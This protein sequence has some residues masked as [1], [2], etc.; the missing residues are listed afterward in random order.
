MSSSMKRCLALAASALMLILLSAAAADEFHLSL[1]V[2]ESVG[3]DRQAEA[4][5]GGVPLPKGVFH[6]DQQLALFKEDGT[7][8][9]CQVSPLVVETD[10]TLRWVLLDFQDH[11]AAGKTNRYRL[12][13][14]KP[15]VRPKEVLQIDDGP[16]EVT[17]DTGKIR[18]SVSRTGPFS[19]FDSV[20]VDGKAVISGGEVS[21]VQLQGR[22]GWDDRAAWRPRKLVAGPPDMV[23]VRYAGPL[24]VTIEVA[25]HFADDPLGAGYKAW[26]TA[27]AGKSRVWLKYKL[28]NSN[29]DRYTAIPVARSTLQLRL[30]R[31]AEEVLLGANRPLAAGDQGWIHQGLLLHYTYQDI[32][33]AVK[34]GNGDNMLWTGNGPKD[35]PAG[36]IATSGAGAVFVCD[37]LFSTNPARRLGADRGN[38]V[39]EGIAERFQ[40][41]KDR[42]FNQDRRVGQPWQSEGFWLYDCSHHT[43][44]YLFDFAPPS[45]PAALDRLAQATRNRLWV[46]A[47]GEYYS[48]CEVLGTGRFGT[49]ADET[50][51]YREW[52]WSFQ[53]TQIPRRSD[54]LPGAF[55]AWEDNHYESEA[56]SVQGLLLMYLRT[57]QRGWFDLAE[58]WARYHMDLQAWRTDGWRWKDG[59]IWFPQGGPQGNRPQREK[60]NFLWGPDWGDRKGSPDCADLWRLAQGKSCYCHYYGSGLADY[61][62]LSGDRDALDAAIDNVEQKDSEF[63][64]SQRFTPGK[65]AVGSIRGFGRGFEVMMRVLQVDPQSQYIR[66]LCHLAARTLWQS[67]LL[68]ERGFHCSH[69]GGGFGGMAAKEISPKVKKWMDENGI[70]LTTVGNTVDTVSKGE[71]SWKVRCMGGTWQH[72]YVQNGADLYARYFDDEDMRDFVIAFAQLSARYMLSPKCHQTWYYTFFDVPDVGMVFDP[73]VFDHADTRDGQGCVH[74][75]WYTRFYPDACAKGYWLTGERHLL[76]KAQEFWYYGSKRRYQSKQLSGGEHEV[77]MFAGHTPPKDDTVLEVSRLFYEASHPRQDD[78][79]PAAIT[80][81]RVK[82]LEGNRAEVRFTAPADAGGGKVIRYQLKAAELPI[83]P[84]EKWDYARDSGKTRNWWRAVNCQGEP[85]PSV[86]GTEERFVVTGLPLGDGF[87]FAIRS[88]DDSNNRSPIS[89]LCGKIGQER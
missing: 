81:L 19:L 21:Y 33:G 32:A 72:V 86:P 8:I 47:P 49:L 78:Q 34:A 40:G 75:G 52:G 85:A 35:R 36:W 48:R 15:S 38:L 22:S 70:R 64:R 37:Q 11:V 23:K 62:C 83:V 69:I 67:P 4:I 25:G 58:A 74:S 3:V 76:E 59:A 10:G 31:H 1:S 26:I 60:W 30:A 73:W 54:P 12:A 80:D 79:P 66:E 50:A 41:P 71:Q 28:C 82:L 87:Y 77:G 65:S 56:D 7:E 2:Q 13:A 17:V 44:E 14:G 27:W 5:S 18:L 51:C 43:S 55:V 46:L 9:P 89:N 16:S 61:F 84:Y 53:P 42:K 29:T 39:L 88:F 20:E 68:D 57:G 24:R 6:K 45:D 63:R